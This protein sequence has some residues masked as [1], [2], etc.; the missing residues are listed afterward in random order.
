MMKKIVATAI[1]LL[2]VQLV[3][4]QVS[5]V[6]GRMI[7]SSS[8]QP[9]SNVT[10]TVPSAKIIG[11]SQGEGQFVLNNLPYGTYNI[12][13]SADGYAEKTVEITVNSPVTN[14]GD[15]EIVADG[16]TNG[17]QEDKL[18]AISLEEISQDA[19]G[20]GS[21]V[22]NVSGVLT[23]SR[24]A[25][26]SATQ[27]TFSSLRFRSRGYDND[28]T[29]VYLNGIPMN[30][31]EN[32]GAFWGQW[33]GLNDVF[34]GRSSIYGLSPNEFGFGGLGLTT[35]LDA[36]ASNQRK[37]TRVSY[38]YS[39]RSYNQR[40][41]FTHSTGLSKNG[42]AFTI[43]GSRRWAEEGY[44]AGTFYD[45]Y[46]YFGAVEKV[47]KKNSLS[48]IA[49]GAPTKRGAAGPAIQEVYDLAGTNFYNPNWGYQNGKKRNARVRDTHQPQ[50]ILTHEYRP[51]ASTLWQTSVGYQFG[52]N[53]YSSLDWY[54]SADPRPDYYRKLPSYQD[55]A[56]MQQLI[57]DY[58]ISNPNS[59]QIDWNS[60]YQANYLSHET[61]Y[62]ANG[63][64]GN[65]ITGKWARYLIGEDHEDSKRFNF[66]TSIQTAASDKVNFYAGLNVQNQKI[67]YFRSIKDLLGADFFV[68]YNQFAE[69]DFPGNNTVAQN[70][71]NH[72]NQVVRVGD[73]YSYNYRMTFNKTTGW[74]QTTVTDT[75]V[76][77]FF[78]ASVSMTSFWRTGYFKNGLFADNSYG[79]SDKLRFANFAFKTGFTYKING[80]NFLFVNGAYL[81]QAPY[82]Q[83]VFLSPRTRN[84]YTGNIKSEE[85]TS[86][87]GGYLLRAPNV[88]ARLVGYATQFNNG[89]ENR[90][91][92]HD[93]LRTLVNYSLSNINRRHMGVEAALDVKVNPT[94]S[95]VA[96]ASMGKFTYTGRANAVIT[97][98][99]SNTIAQTKLIYWKNY[100]VPSGPQKAY[101][102]GL[103]YRSKKYWF[104]NIN[105]N[106]YTDNWLDFNPDRRT[107]EAVDLVP[108]GSAQWHAILD[109]KKA[110][111]A[112]TVD[113]FGGKSWRLNNIMKGVPS[114][115]FLYFNMGVNNL[116]NK[117]DIVVAG[118]EQLR[119]NF[120]E[121]DPNTFPPKYFY[122]FGIN[123]FASLALRF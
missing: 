48:L 80:R 95:V 11:T 42:W 23:A 56:N 63:I 51:S 46:S 98:D 40:V 101:T 43:S 36:S 38:A 64:T 35:S 24:D 92:Y 75:K 112:F 17:L 76:D 65:N 3:I 88:K 31:L 16:P 2:T 27:F 100:Y 103:N 72:P 106:Y 78:A 62:N 21:N 79:N 45:A 68:N 4:A 32:G 118:F 104:L 52:K 84:D 90:N 14:I 44:V 96:V 25:F 71:L 20:E 1:I 55:S 69:R 22:Q 120:N 77:F 107:V 109:Q 47:F 89:V 12:V 50:F 41:M 30:D 34:R 59:L 110:D 7:A 114:N 37:Q 5:T 94:L 82:V 83:N 123:F 99:N 54:N 9:V 19:S 70:D 53:A 111:P 8:K 29:Q 13:V 97:Q 119:Y 57:K 113:F 60:L 28:Q 102:L 117:K 49:F 66:N 18:P 33:G 121:R 61:V 58:I 86:I 108:E 15:I 93:D 115:Y 81:T 122:G 67:D 39:N 6:K 73:K 105:A 116:L 10:V 85:I 26:V 91:Y 87:E 74:L